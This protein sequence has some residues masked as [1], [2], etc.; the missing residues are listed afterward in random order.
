MLLTSFG[1]S[2]QATETHA[3][4]AMTET[5][6]MEIQQ[7]VDQIKAMDFTQLNNAERKNLRHELKDM[8][9]EL[10]QGPYIYISAGAL[11]LIIILIILLL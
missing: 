5:R 1:Y 9:T 2:A 3:A 8:K 7:R 6:A 10:K 4:A 11:I